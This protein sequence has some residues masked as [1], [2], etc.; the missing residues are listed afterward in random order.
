MNDRH[1]AG[2]VGAIAKL[3]GVSLRSLDARL[4]GAD[5][6]D[7]PI[8]LDLGWEITF[9]RPGPDAVT[10][11]YQLAVSEPTGRF[12]IDCSYELEYDLPGD[13]EIL[14]ED[15]VAF[16]E[17]S[18]AFSA[19]PYARELVQSLTTRASLPPLVLGTLRAP[20]DPPHGDA[21]TE[22]RPA[23]PLDLKTDW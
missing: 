21:A 16:G 5:S 6:A 11:D 17:I 1:R 3:C 20:I 23:D 2:K 19:F 9:S 10:F 18:V 13:K 22:G 7:A 8:E 15:L 4:V 12:R 14:D